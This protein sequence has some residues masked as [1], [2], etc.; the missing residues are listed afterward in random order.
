MSAYLRSLNIS[1][2]MWNFQYLIQWL[3]WELHQ[4]SIGLFYY[5]WQVIEESDNPADSSAS[6]SQGPSGMISYGI[7]W[8]W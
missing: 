3:I 4:A 6:S 8:A 1:V 5:A 7:L 2:F